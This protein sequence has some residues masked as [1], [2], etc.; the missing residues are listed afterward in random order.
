[1]RLRSKN[2]E[3]LLVK[4][5]IVQKT[6]IRSYDKEIYMIDYGLLTL[7]KRK[8]KI[9]FNANSGLNIDLIENMY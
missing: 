6:I 8:I 2:K 4:Q 3:K 9:S 1:M 5:N 7:I